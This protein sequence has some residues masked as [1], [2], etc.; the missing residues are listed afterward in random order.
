MR[1]ALKML[2]LN[3]TYHMENVYLNELDCK[4]WMDALAAKYDGGKPFGRKEWD[5]L[6][7]HCQVSTHH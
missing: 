3:E 1:E 5:Q 6:L 7:G 4:L 2:G